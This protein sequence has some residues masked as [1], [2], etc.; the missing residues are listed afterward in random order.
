[1]RNP[2]AR[3]AAA[4]A[5]SHSALSAAERKRDAAR[6]SASVATIS[7]IAI[8]V[9]SLVASRRETSE[10]GAPTGEICAPA[11]ITAGAQTRRHVSARATRVPARAQ[12][13][14]ADGTRVICIRT[15]SRRR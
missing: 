5:I 15:A 3:S 14:A 1:M 2:V 8:R 7:E 10:S 6:G 12:H 4:R 9:P 13:R 11:E